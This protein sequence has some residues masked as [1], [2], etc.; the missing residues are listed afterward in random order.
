MKRRPRSSA[1][2]PAAGADS[3]ATLSLAEAAIKLG[4][5][6]KATRRAAMIGQIPTIRIGRR[7]LVLRAPL[8]ALLSGKPAPAEEEPM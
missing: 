5:S 3:R 2:E 8:E 4:L 7:W 1:G 6:L